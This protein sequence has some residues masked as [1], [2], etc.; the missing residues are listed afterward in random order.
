MAGFSVSN[1]VCFMVVSD[2]LFSGIG[3]YQQGS[4]YRCIFRTKPNR[5]WLQITD[6]STLDDKQGD[7]YVSESIE[8]A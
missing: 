2:A 3:E 7:N 5:I 6:I 1:H 4:V 8:E